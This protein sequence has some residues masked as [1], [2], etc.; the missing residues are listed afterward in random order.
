MTI[1]HVMKKNP[2]FLYV[3]FRIWFTC[4][5]YSCFLTQTK[6]YIAISNLQTYIVNQ[7]PG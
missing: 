1:L 7:L 2:T 6:Y 5:L 4:L 3:T